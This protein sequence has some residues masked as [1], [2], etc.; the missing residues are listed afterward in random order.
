MP[1]FAAFLVVVLLFAC[2]HE[3][4]LDQRVLTGMQRSEIRELLGEPD[5][6]EE[7]I[8]QVP[9]IFGP[10]EGIWDRMEMGDTLVTWIYETSNGRKEVYFVNDDPEVAGEF[11]WYHDQSKNPVF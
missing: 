7:L 9:Y 4:G 6:T 2:S 10:V 3:P 8:K 5:E 11:F 1:R